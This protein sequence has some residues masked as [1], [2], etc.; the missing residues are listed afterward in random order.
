MKQ[1]DGTLEHEAGT[2][3]IILCS[4]KN[5]AMAKITLPEN[6]RI[7]AARYQMYLPT[8]DEL[9]AELARERDEV[10][11]ALALAKASRTD[12]HDGGP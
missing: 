4:Q 3:G 2:I 12:P 5:E 8:E 9:R 11:K 10:E 6:S 1:A 7:L